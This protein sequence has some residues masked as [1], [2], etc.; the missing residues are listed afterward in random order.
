MGWRFGEVWLDTD[1]LWFREQPRQPFGA[2]A[3]A[4]PAAADALEPVL[5]MPVATGLEA[6]RRRRLER[7]GGASAPTGDA[8]GA[9]GGARPRVGHDAPDC[10]APAARRRAGRRPACRQTLRASRSGSTAPAWRFPGCT[11]RASALLRDARPSRAHPPERLSSHESS[12]TAPRRLA[13]SIPAV[14]STARSFP[15][16]GP[17]GSR[18]TRSRT[19]LR[20]CPA[21]STATSARS[22]RSSP[23][24]PRT[25]P[26]MRTRR[27]SSSATSAC[28]DGGSMDQHVSHQNG[29]DVDVYYPRL[30]RHPSAPRATQPD[31]PRPLA[32]SPRPLRRRGGTGR[33]RRLLD[34]APR[35]E[36]RRR[37]VPEPREPHA[38]ALPAFPADGRPPC[39]A[40]VWAL[41]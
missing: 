30:D 23:C 11:S 12:G 14:S 10:R 15:S 1:M 21:G 7:P 25:A 39:V 22:G 41:D 4:M 3:L 18:G 9:R 8:H 31:R 16:R 20:T 34:R 19:A 24:S 36:R 17:T 38:R 40:D 28:R 32:G 33:L 29:L 37:P 27:A 26:R 35:S 2:L 13:S 5:F 6:S